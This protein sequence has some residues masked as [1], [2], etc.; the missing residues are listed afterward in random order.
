MCATLSVY[1]ACKIENIH[2]KY[3]TFQKFYHENKS[4]F[5]AL[6]LQNAPNKISVLKSEA[7]PNQP[8]TAAQKLK[9]KLAA[10]KAQN[11]E[12]PVEVVPFE[13]VKCQLE[14]RFCDLELKM[15]SIL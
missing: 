2:L 11:I 7:T 3:E 12:K 13:Q 10:K 8:M 9:A 14:E 6:Q 15:L 4:K 1:L 5:K